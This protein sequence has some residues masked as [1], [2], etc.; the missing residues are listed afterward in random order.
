MKRIFTLLAAVA[1]IC[2]AV[3]AE[4][5]TYGVAGD[6]LYAVG[7]GVA[8]QNYSSAIEVPA[9]VAATM[10]GAKVTEISFGF[11]SGNNKIVT[12]F[13]TKELGGEPIYTE[14]FKRNSTNAYNTF[15]LQT[16]YTIDGEK[17]YIG[18]NYRQSTSSGSPVC[19]DRVLSQTDMGFSYCAVYKDGE[20]PDY[21]SF[22]HDQGNLSLRATIEGDNLP[23]G[24]VL[25]YGIKA[26]AF[27]PIGQTVDYSLTF[28]NMGLGAVSSVEISSQLGYDD[29]V[30]KTFPVS[31]AINPGETATVSLSG[32]SMLDDMYLPIA[33]SIAKVNGQEALFS[34][35][36]GS[37]FFSNSN[38]ISFRKVVFE[39][40]TGLMCPWCPRGYVALEDMRAKYPDDVINISLHN[41]NNGYGDA[42]YCES[43]KPWNNKWGTGAPQ[44]TA[45]RIKIE[46]SSAHFQSAYD[47]LHQTIPMSMQVYAWLKDGETNVLETGVVST[48]G[49]DE[50]NVDFGIAMVYTRDGMGPYSQLNQY[51]G[52]S[53]GAM[54]GFEKMGNPVSLMYNDIARYIWNFAGAD[55]S[56]PTDIEAKHTYGYKFEMPLLAADANFHND[57]NIIALLI[58][59]KTGQIVTGAKCKIGEKQDIDA[60]VEADVVD[61][62]AP[63]ATVTPVA[64]GVILTGEFD[65][66]E[67]FTINGVRVAA[68]TECGQ[69][70]LP[71][72]IYAV[73][74]ISAGQTKTTKVIL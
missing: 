52:G 73:R 72:G 69:I 29:P 48:Y 15:T 32:S 26:P 28:K 61:V 43:Y 24:L 38:L 50:K 49:Y 54:G 56:V 25:P 30:V 45:N 68:T 39:E 11:G 12:V 71:A 53:V 58:N 4:K 34:S 10:K 37:T 21:K 18:W 57:L 74:T 16:P 19:F 51:A 59:R 36:V 47:E 70:A 20:T 42:M 7:T 9:N 40:N 62:V 27:S 13:I 35:A 5:L 3:S 60:L 41:Y 6:K 33:F 65:L 44:A 66:A 22:A 46:V 31:P 63:Q 67:V 17:F 1:I 14:E 55:N 8:G 2:G 23:K 64:G